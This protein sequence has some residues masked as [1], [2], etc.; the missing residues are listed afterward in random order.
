NS[1]DL[2]GYLL[3]DFD[4]GNA[5]YV[6]EWTDGVKTTS[7]SPKSYRA[8]T[9]TTD[10]QTYGLKRAT[11]NGCE[12]VLEHATVTLHRREAATIPSYGATYC[13]QT[14][15][16][17]TSPWQPSLGANLNWGLFPSNPNPANPKI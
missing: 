15:I 11:A 10:T 3:V 14:D 4:G 5:P 6:W 13:T 9:N 17:V 1:A 2:T 16:T 8:V 7:M 12:A